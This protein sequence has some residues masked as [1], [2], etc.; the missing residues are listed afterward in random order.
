MTERFCYY[1]P[2][3]A[4]TPEGYIPSMVVEHEP[5]HR[6]MTG[7]A[8]Q[9]PWYWGTNREEAEAIAMHMNARMGLSPQ[10]ASEIVASSM[11][12]KIQERLQ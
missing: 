9:E 2:H 12:A 10:D 8:N 3:D 5:G 7:D 4:K 11:F 6:P 1:I